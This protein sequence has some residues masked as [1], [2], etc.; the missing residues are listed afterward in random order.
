MKRLQSKLTMVSVKGVFWSRF[1]RSTSRAQELTDNNADKNNAKK[2][3]K[4]DPLIA[5]HAV[6]M[7]L[8]RS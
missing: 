7:I 6:K 8:L 4:E 5:L 2:K 1:M 3:I